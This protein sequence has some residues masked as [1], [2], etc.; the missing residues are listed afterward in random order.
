MMHV[1]GCRP[2]MGLGTDVPRG[3]TQTEK[4]RVLPESAHLGRSVQVHCIGLVTGLN[5]AISTEMIAKEE[6]EN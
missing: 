1:S 4:L 6:G 2:D 3:L 5:R